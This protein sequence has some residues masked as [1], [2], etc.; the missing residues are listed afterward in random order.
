MQ[1][2]LETQQVFACIPHQG[3]RTVNSIGVVSGSADCCAE[4]LRLSLEFLHLCDGKVE[5]RNDAKCKFPSLAP[6]GERVA[7]IRRSHQPGRDG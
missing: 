7:R 3:V 2:R 1:G 4:R 5:R 6:L